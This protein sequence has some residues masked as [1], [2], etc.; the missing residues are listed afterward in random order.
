MEW[1]GG[2]AGMQQTVH[3]AG[4]KVKREH[5]DGCAN[6]TVCRVQVMLLLIVCVRGPQNRSW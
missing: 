3:S 1:Q 5:G 2:S 6:D 4:C